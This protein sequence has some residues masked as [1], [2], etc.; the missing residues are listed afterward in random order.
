MRESGPGDKSALLGFSPV[1]NGPTDASNMQEQ[2]FA[3]SLANDGIDAVNIFPIAPD[4]ENSSEE[5]NYSPMW[6]A[7]V[8]MWTEA[9]IADG[10]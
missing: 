4:N 1:L 3:A 5:N 10:K 6:D 7:H 2:G 9:A 8:N